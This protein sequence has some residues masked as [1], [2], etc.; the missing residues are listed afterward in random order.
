[1]KNTFPGTATPYNVSASRN[2]TIVN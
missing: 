2:L 1:V